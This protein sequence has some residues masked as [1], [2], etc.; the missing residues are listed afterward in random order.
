MLNE[1]DVQK[2]YDD[3]AKALKELGPGYEHFKTVYDSQLYV[4]EKVLQK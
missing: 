3:I 4:L 2:L 1:E